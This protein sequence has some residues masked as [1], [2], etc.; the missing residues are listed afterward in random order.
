MSNAIP[1]PPPLPTGPGSPRDVPPPADDPIA[2]LKKA[3]EMLDMGLITQGDFDAVKA[4]VLG[5]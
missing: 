5:L 1:P 2:K 4:K 3:K